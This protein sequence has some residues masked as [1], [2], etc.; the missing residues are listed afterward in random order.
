MPSHRFT[1]SCLHV[2]SMILPRRLWLPNETERD[3]RQPGGKDRSRGTARGR[4]GREKRSLALLPA[5]EWTEETIVE[6]EVE[7]KL[8]WGDRAGNQS[9]SCPSFLPLYSSFVHH[10]S[11]RT[12]FWLPRLSRPFVLLLVFLISNFTRRQ[13]A[14]GWAHCTV[15][16]NFGKFRFEVTNSPARAENRMVP[17]RRVVL[18]ELTKK[19][20]ILSHYRG[21]RSF[22]DISAEKIVVTALFNLERYN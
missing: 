7:Y 18:L 2:D 14:I 22:S 1:G 8:S 15:G 17:T 10:L 16:K 20:R 12:P 11:S 19:G 21:Q 9:T 13:P 4:R 6:Y 5:H 3:E